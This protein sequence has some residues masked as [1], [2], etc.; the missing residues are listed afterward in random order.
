V[1]VGAA[2]RTPR[3]R[4]IG[5]RKLKRTEC[6]CANR[7]EAPADREAAIFA[8]GATHASAQ[9]FAVDRRWIADQRAA[10]NRSR[11]KAR[12]RPAAGTSHITT[13]HDGMSAAA[14]DREPA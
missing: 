13:V 2:R 4:R 1:A 7:I 5:I 6:S 11:A 10:R 8:R 9:W 3:T 12:L 14:D